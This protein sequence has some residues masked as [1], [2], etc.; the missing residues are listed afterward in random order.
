VNISEVKLQMLIV[1]IS[2]LCSNLNALNFGS[3]PRTHDMSHSTPRDW[4][5]LS[6]TTALASSRRHTSVSPGSGA[7]FISGGF[8][9]GLSSQL[10]KYRGINIQTLK[11]QKKTK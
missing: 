1:V 6:P 4:S 5:G 7:E 10:G 9:S 11:I 2:G 3:R 8:D